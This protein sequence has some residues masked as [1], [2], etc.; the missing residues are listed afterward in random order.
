MSVIKLIGSDP[1]QVSRNRDLGSMA[2]QSLENVVVENLTVDTGIQDDLA[3]STGNLVIGTEGKGV[4]TGSSIPLGFGVNNGTSLMTLDIYGQLGLGTTSPELPIHIVS[5][6]PAIS[7]EESDA[8]A[9]NKKWWF[10]ASGGVYQARLLNDAVNAASTWLKVTRSGTTV[11]SVEFPSSNVTVSTGNLVIG[12]SGKGIDFSADGQAAGM[13]SELLD[14][15]E[16]GTWTPVLLNGTSITYASQIG[17][18]TKIGNLVHVEAYLNVSNNDT[19]DG[20]NVAI[21]G[22]PFPPAGI[23]GV[24]CPVFGINIYEQTFLNIATHGNP[25]LNFAS[26]PAIVINYSYSQCNV[27]GNLRLSASYRV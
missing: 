18:Y 4:T 6:Y 2:Y 8:T 17:Y 9:N 20:S 22:L 19:S 24:A 26:A 14:D 12:T 11:S 25:A 5:S 7:L 16:E 15:Y 13:T 27:S 21:G 23:S 10:E 1:N 3:L